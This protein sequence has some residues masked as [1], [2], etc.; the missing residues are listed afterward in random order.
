MCEV[1]FMWSNLSASRR[2]LSIM[3]CSTW[4]TA[5]CQRKTII[6]QFSGVWQIRSVPVDWTQASGGGFAPLGLSVTWTWATLRHSWATEELLK[7]MSKGESEMC[8]YRDTAPILWK[9]RRS[10]W[11]PWWLRSHTLCLNRQNP[12]REPR[13]LMRQVPT[14]KSYKGL[15]WFQAAVEF[16]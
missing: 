10:S 3:L 4:H 8:R 12:P 2:W 1:A 9:L 16:F 15:T 6:K 13:C 11:E 5:L 7:E 14:G